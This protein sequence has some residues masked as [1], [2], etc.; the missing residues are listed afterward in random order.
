MPTN[1]RL[2]LDTLQTGDSVTLVA[3]E[4]P[5]AYSYVFTVREPGEMPLCDLTQINPDGSSV[6]PG[7]AVLQGCGRWTTEAQNPMQRADWFIGRPRQEIAM[8]IGYGVL[9]VGGFIIVS[10]PGNHTGDRFQ[11]QPECTDIRLGKPAGEAS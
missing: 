9:F 10:E 3:G 6:G 4:E 1:E 8:S 5:E 7:A 11:L 2:N